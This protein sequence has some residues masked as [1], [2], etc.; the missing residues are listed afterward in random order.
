[1][2]KTT[3]VD[4]VTR[5]TAAFLNAIFAHV[6][7]GVDSDGH[8]AKIDLAAAAN[9]TG[10]L[11][12]ANGGHGIT[13][14]GNFVLTFPSG[15]DITFNYRLYDDGTVKFWW[16]SQTGLDSGA[17]HNSPSSPGTFPAAIKPSALRAANC[18]LG[19]AGTESGMITINTD[20]QIT[21]SALS[22]A[23]TTIVYSG[24][25]FYKL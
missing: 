10:L 13:G 18:F 3:F 7:D 1:M 6:H 19:G 25:I 2:A 20:G 5:V 22:G 9:V 21:F 23:N 17:T 4:N 11:P 12:T 24:A 15:K 8:A 16:E 14:S